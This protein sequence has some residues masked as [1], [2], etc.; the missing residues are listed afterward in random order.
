M[1]DPDEDIDISAI[2]VLGNDPFDLC[3]PETSEVIDR[4]MENALREA[5]RKHKKAGVPMVISREGEIV[6]LQ[7]DEID[8]G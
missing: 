3:S 2:Y 7:P 4:A 8:I 1:T 6:H 5:R